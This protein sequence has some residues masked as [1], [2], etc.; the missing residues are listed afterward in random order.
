MRWTRRRERFMYID[1]VVGGFRYLFQDFDK[2]SVA[3]TAWIL[4]YATFRAE[5][6]RCEWI[7]AMYEPAPPGEQSIESTYI[8][9]PQLRELCTMHDVSQ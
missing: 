3:R 5:Q 6:T 8:T 7:A 1:A 2:L 9:D 4:D